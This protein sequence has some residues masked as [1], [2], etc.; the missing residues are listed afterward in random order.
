MFTQL[1]QAETSQ[2]QLPP[3][4]VRRWTLDESHALVDQGIFDEN[5]WNCWKAGLLP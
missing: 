4:P 5:G 3:F 2:D 1:I